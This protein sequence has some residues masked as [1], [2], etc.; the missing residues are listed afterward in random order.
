[1][2][3]CFLVCFLSMCL[4]KFVLCM[5]WWHMGHFFFSFVFT[6][7]LCICS[8]GVDGRVVVVVIAGSGMVVV[9][10][11]GSGMVLVAVVGTANLIFFGDGM[12]VNVGAGIVLVMS[13]CFSLHEDKCLMKSD[14][15]NSI[16]WQWIQW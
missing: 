1:M 12:V 3:F 14:L 8:L 6:Q 11:I 16:D 9:F 15:R 2:S 5:S 13:G 10:V 7:T 4:F